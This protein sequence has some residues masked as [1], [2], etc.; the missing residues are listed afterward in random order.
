MPAASSRRRRKASRTSLPAQRSVAAGASGLGKRE[1][2]AKG[3][4]DLVNPP[5]QSVLSM[6]HH[7]RRVQAE[8]IPQEQDTNLARRSKVAGNFGLLQFPLVFCAL[9]PGH[10]LRDLSSGFKGY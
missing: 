4:K 7:P 8:H 5:S 2:V 6:Q 1:A 9:V 3:I 10:L